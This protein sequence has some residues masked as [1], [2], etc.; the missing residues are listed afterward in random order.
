M[1]FRASQALKIAFAACAR[2]TAPKQ[3]TE[4]YMKKPK[5]VIAAGNTHTAR[6]ATEILTA[7]GNAFDAAAAAALMTF[8]AESTLTSAAGG[9]FLLAHTATGKSTLYDFFVQ[10]PKQKRAANELEFYP[11]HIDFGDAR[12]EFHIGLGAAA[13]SGCLRGIWD[14]QKEL[15]KLPMKEVI[16]PAVEAARNGLEV[17]PFMQHCMDLVSPIQQESPRGREI[18]FRKGK[19]IQPGDTHKMPQYADLLENLE[20]E[21][22]SLFYEG[23]VAQKIV[24]ECQERGG[25]LQMNDFR[26][27]KT[28]RRNPLAVPFRNYELLTN[29]LPSAGGS[30][31]A[32]MLRL[33]EK[34][35]FRPE[36]FGSARHLNVLAEAMRQAHRARIQDF[37][38]HIREGHDVD[39]LLDDEYLR[40]YHQTLR[41]LTL[42]IGSTTHFTVADDEGNVASVTT[43]VGEGCGYMIPGTDIMLNNMLGEE[44]LNPDGFHQWATDIRMTSMMAPTMILQDGKPKIALGSGGANR[45]RTAIPQVIFN[46]L[47][48]GMAGKEAV[49]A[50]RMH[51]EEGVLDCEPG[52]SDTSLRH[53]LQPK[54]ERLAVWAKQGM[55]FGGTHSIFWD[56]HGT[57][58]P[59]GDKR[60]FGAEASA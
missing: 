48:L 3:E 14:V 46:H 53:L 35:Q 1:F 39:R 38:H 2:Q 22:I 33:L 16:R 21:G 13:V 23:E 51:W 44:D 58:Q 52:F 25:H 6:A 24:K 36:E 29:P 17:T 50:S 56:E 40:S 42:K 43:S 49:S 19:L 7:G 10:T 20:R 34:Q 18:Y 9:G 15:G 60:R 55:F 12:Q 30:L 8:I 4:K 11:I 47:A 45:I 31:I 28:L 54:G 27:F 59:V 41:E 32:F 5:G 57:P 26:D 37:N